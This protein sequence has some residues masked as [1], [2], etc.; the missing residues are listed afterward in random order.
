MIQVR[1]NLQQLQSRRKISRIICFN[2]NCNIAWRTP[3]HPSS[4]SSRTCSPYLSRKGHEAHS[5]HV[6][7][8][9]LSCMG[10]THRKTSGAYPAPCSLGRCH[11]WL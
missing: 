7:P 4:P 2:A 5:G 11:A 8:S 10:L 1:L 6:V 3:I 9:L